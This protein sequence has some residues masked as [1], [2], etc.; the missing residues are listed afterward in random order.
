VKTRPRIKRQTA[1]AEVSPELFDFF[2]GKRERPPVDY[3]LMGRPEALRAAWES[4]AEEICDHWQ[5][6][7]PG[8]RPPCWWTYSAPEQS[9][10]QLSGGGQP[11]W[12]EF[13]MVPF[14]HCGLPQAWDGFKPDDPPTFESQASFLQRHGLLAKHEAS[15]ADFRPEAMHFDFDYASIRATLARL[16]K[17]EPELL[18]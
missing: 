18:R 1:A 3:Y 5:A 13:A 12:I 16:E 8:T 4:I 14:F 7:F 2:A 15:K 10:R 17:K 11:A 9:R 6:D